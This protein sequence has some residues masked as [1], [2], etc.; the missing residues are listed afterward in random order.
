MHK[1]LASS[2]L[3]IGIISLSFGAEKYD[4]TAFR[5]VTKLCTSCHGKIHAVYKTTDIVILAFRS[6]LH[7]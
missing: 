6:M 3:F 7:Y 5:T 1:A 2:L 4:T